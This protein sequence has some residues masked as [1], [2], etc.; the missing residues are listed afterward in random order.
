MLPKVF[1]F[2]QTCSCKF[3]IVDIFL[4]VVKELLWK[5]FQ[6]WVGFFS[7]AITNFNIKDTHF[8]WFGIS[9]IQPCSTQLQCS[10]GYKET[11][12][13]HNRKEYIIFILL[14]AHK[15]NKKEEKIFIKMCKFICMVTNLA[16]NKMFSKH[17]DV[18]FL[19][20]WSFPNLF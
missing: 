4:A 12:R 19:N 2:F 17:H 20:I 15:W 18:A 16:V 14:W 7:F 8:C 9:N 5:Q 11:E 13:S 6:Y 1:A 3:W 10:M